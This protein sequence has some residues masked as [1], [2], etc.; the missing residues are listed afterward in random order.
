MVLGLSALG[1]GPLARQ[2]RVTVLPKSDPAGYPAVKDLPEVEVPASEWKQIASH[3]RASPCDRRKKFVAGEELVVLK[4]AFRTATPHLDLEP[5]SPAG[6][7]DVSWKSAIDLEC[8]EDSVVLALGKRSLEMDFVDASLESDVDGK[9]I[10]FAGFS[11]SKMHFAL[12][13]IHTA[14]KTDRDGFVVASLQRYMPTQIGEAHVWRNGALDELFV[15]GMGSGAKSGV[16]VV[17]PLY[18]GDELRVGIAKFRV[19]GD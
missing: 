2:D 19:V 6:E 3:T 10:R 4:E 11:A 8:S 12:G 16:Y 15:G 1:C 7:G 5:R 17:G 13:L 9:L 14:A 18:E